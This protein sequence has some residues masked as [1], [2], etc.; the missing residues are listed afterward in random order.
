MNCPTCGSALSERGFFCK[1][2]A[3]QARC[4][5]CK[6]I[7]EPEAAACV[8]CG[9]TVGSR[10]A[11]GVPSATNI[12]TAPAHRNTIAFREDRNSR[13]FE[14]S[15][16]D[17]AMQGIGGVLGEFIVQRASPQGVQSQRR[18]NREIE[19]L[20]SNT[21]PASTVIEGETETVDTLPPSANVVPPPSQENPERPR[22][23]RI[24]TV[25]GDSFEL[26]D[27]RLKAK[28]G[29]E[30]LR[31]LTYLFLYAHEIWG[32]PETNE[33]ELK[34]ILKAA[35]IW[36]ESGNAN[37]WLNKRNGITNGDEDKVKL[38]ASGREEAVKTLNEAHDTN[39]P[40]TWNPDKNTPKPR[41]AAKKQQK[42]A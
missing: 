6:E 26:S 13:S 10:P 14:A 8:E 40:D 29:A 33:A 28:S 23:L 35:K 38:I 41:P 11:N 17:H 12:A 20:P 39:V 21:L 34:R 15:L 22:L 1:A 42:K 2:C 3:A 7:L 9:T 16:T 30:Y 19:V 18:V 31:R 32:R 4:F 37:R 27:N 25:K 5:S 24:F 36:D